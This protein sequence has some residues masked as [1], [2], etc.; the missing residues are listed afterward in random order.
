MVLEGECLATS[1]LSRTTTSYLSREIKWGYVFA[2]C[3]RWDTNSKQYIVDHKRFN[4]TEELTIPLCSAQ[5]LNEV[6][7]DIV[8]QTKSPSYPSSILSS[9]SN[10][11][12]P[13]YYRKSDIPNIN[14]LQEARDLSDEETSPRSTKAIVH[15][16]VN[17]MNGSDEEYDSEGDVEYQY[18]TFMDLSIEDLK[19]EKKLRKK[20]NVEIRKKRF[21]AAEGRNNKSLSGT[22]KE[23]FS[24]LPR[25][26]TEGAGR[27][28]I[29]KQF[30]ETDF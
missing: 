3:T 8:Y 15:Q 12:S 2:P 29:S 4:K 11:T 20:E 27:R 23:F 30:E 13:I 21:D 14:E 10:L 5:R 17:L 24:N 26:V 18:P 9:P 22:V 7:D 6:Y 25:Y 28:R 19:E 1:Y 16:M